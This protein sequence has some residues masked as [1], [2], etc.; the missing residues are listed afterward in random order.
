MGL[1]E[2]KKQQTRD[3]LLSIAEDMFNV[4]DFDAVTIE[5]IISRAHI[6][7]KTFFNYFQ[8]K[9]KLLEDWALD[10]FARNNIWS[11]EAD[12]D[13]DSESALLPP[14]LDEMLDWISAHRRLLKMVLKHTDLLNGIR[15][16]ETSGN[17][18]PN[19][20]IADLRP[21]R[22]ARV[23]TAQQA[24]IIRNDISA[25]HICDMYDSLRFDV[26][27]RWLVQADDRANAGNLK[28]HFNIIMKVFL[29]GIRPE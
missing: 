15:P 25:E 24:G 23:E 14:H 3:L 29:K 26:V 12:I 8:G 21:P 9:S 18:A 6:S 13:F 22:L 19:T 1:R 20:I 10:W 11:R 2:D 4:R 7:R 16:P 17:D 5:D 27:R 28:S